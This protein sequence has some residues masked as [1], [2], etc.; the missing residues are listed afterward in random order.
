[1]SAIAYLHPKEIRV[2]AHIYLYGTCATQELAD[3]IAEEINRMWNEPF[4]EIAWAG[5]SRLVRFE[6][7]CSSIG[8][9]STLTLMETNTNHEVN[10]VRIEEENI[11]KRSMMGYG[12]GQ[13]SGHW[14]VGDQLGKSTTA[15]HEF[16]HALGLPHPSRIDYRGQGAPPLMCP[17]GTWVDAEYQWNP[18]VQVHEFGGTMNPKHR[19]VHIDEVRAIL[20]NAEYQSDGKWIIGEVVNTFYDELGRK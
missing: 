7:F 13:N 10:F 4:V 19:K 11:L 5:V 2:R 8:C 18:L 14:I 15:A 9:E 6:V 12:L 16:G 3:A 17:R 20:E 1:M